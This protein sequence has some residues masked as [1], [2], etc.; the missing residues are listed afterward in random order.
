M[1][2]SRRDKKYLGVDT[3]V[4]VAF[5]DKKHPDHP[6]A[7][8]LEDFSDTATNPTIIHEAESDKSDY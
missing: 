1:D 7:K 4:L 5:L 8:K 2:Y 3:N 6:E